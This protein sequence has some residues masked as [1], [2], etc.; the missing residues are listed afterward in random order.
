MSR[1]EAEVRRALLLDGRSLDM[2]SVRRAASSRGLVMTDAQ[3]AT[4]AAELSS[5]HWPRSWLIRA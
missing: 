4:V 2:R 1:H 3:V 5:D